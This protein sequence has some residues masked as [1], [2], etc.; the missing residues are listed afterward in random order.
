ME[1]SDDEGIPAPELGDSDR[2]QELAS[3]ISFSLRCIS[4]ASYVDK[5]CKKSDESA[6]KKAVST[7]EHGDR[8]CQVLIVMGMGF[9]YMYHTKTLETASEIWEWADTR[10][11]LGARPLDDLLAK[12]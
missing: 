9:K 5:D 12:F 7:W 6:G 10:Y 1:S 4:L 11:G 3:E 2:Y 8:E